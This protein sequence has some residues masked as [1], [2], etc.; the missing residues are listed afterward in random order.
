MRIAVI[1]FGLVRGAEISA[2]SIEQKLIEP[3]A[4][5]GVSFTKIMATNLVE[6][7]W[8]PRSHEF[9]A[10]LD[11]RDVFRFDCE[12][13]VL[14]RQ[15]DNSIMNELSCAKRHQD[16]FQNDWISIRNLLHQL[17]SLECGWNFCEKL[18]YE[19]FDAFLFLRPDLLYVD[20]FDIPLLVSRLK[21]PN[22]LLVP[23][24]HCWGGLNDRFALAGPV[25]ARRYALRLK[26]VAEFC[27]HYPLHS[28]TFLAWALAEAKCCI[29]SLPI[30]ALRVR[31]DGRVENENFNNAFL[32][33]P[34]EAVPFSFS[35]QR[36]LD[37]VLP[38]PILHGNKN[39]TF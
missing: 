17:S 13:Y 5:V 11:H 22:T 10:I 14:N 27:R 30:R 24:W 2:T 32:N 15:N 39:D 18:R 3:N 8:N 19:E 9:N 21:T 28:E 1:Y 29:G 35:T 26:H 25:A 36:G 7:V 37:A 16:I 38:K 34:I 4:A 33:L 6:R 20:N 23:P 31:A 12:H